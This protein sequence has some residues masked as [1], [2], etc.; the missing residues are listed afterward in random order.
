LGRRLPVA[1]SHDEFDALANSVN[2]VLDRLEDQAGTL[3]ATFDSA[4]H[5]LRAPLHRLRTRMD[6]LLLHSPP[7][8]PAVRDSI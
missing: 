5:D 6:A 3:R 1:G 7:L 4:A 2:H 8:E